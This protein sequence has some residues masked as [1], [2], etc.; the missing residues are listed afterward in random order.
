MSVTYAST[1][2]GISTLESQD[3]QLRTRSQSPRPESSRH[4]RQNSRSSELSGSS[5]AHGELPSPPPPVAATA[6]AT[7]RGDMMLRAQYDQIG[8]FFGGGSVGS[9]RPMPRNDPSHMFMTANAR[10]YDAIVSRKLFKYGFI[11]FPLWIVGIAAPFVKP[12]RD[13][14]LDNRS[15]EEQDADYSDMREEEIRWAKRCGAA[16][17]GFASIVIISIAV[18]VTVSRQN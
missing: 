13:P 12:S 2:F 10:N 11:F 15:K 1:S 8:A 9:N 18:G 4:H 14:S 3:S 7:T 16:L 17:A 5:T 6:Q